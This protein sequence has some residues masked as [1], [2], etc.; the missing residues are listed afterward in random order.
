MSEVKSTT[1]F[2]IRVNQ[3]TNELLKEL[4]NRYRSK[5][6][7]AE[8][9]IE[10][11]TNGKTED[12]NVN[13]LKQIIDSQSKELS[14]LK[15]KINAGNSDANIVVPLTSL[16]QKCVQ[17]LVEREIRRT[18]DSNITAAL[19]MQFMLEVFLIDGAIFDIAPVPDKIVNQ[20]IK[21]TENAD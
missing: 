5:Q 16:Q 14:E 9:V 19:F 3:D 18:G 1:T 4:A 17:Y 10:R 8:D 7:F 11:L 15:Q 6:E 13:E 2:G 20:F 21:E 12:N